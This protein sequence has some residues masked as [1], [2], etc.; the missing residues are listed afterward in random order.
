MLFIYLQNMIYSQVIFFCNKQNDCR[1][2]MYCN[3]LSE[4]DYCDNI[5]PT[6]CDTLNTDCC[7]QYF[8]YQCETNPFQCTTQEPVEKASM[9]KYLELFLILFIVINVCYLPTGCIYNF[10][11]GKKGMELLPHRTFWENL[12][13]LVKDGCWFS[14]QKCKTYCSYRLYNRILF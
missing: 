13:G 1:I 3:T 14:F 2:G 5:S 12:F 9:N 4:C 8:L 7:S 6:S 10:R 11:K